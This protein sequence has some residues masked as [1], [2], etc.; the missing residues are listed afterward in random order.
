MTQRGRSKCGGAGIQRTAWEVRESLKRF[1]RLRR[2]SPLRSTRATL[3]P[4]LRFGNRKQNQNSPP[5]TR[6]NQIRA[7][8]ESIRRTF[9]PACPSRCVCVYNWFSAVCQ[10]NP[11]PLAEAK[12]CRGLS[13]RDAALPY[14]GP[15]GN[16]DQERLELGV[17]VIVREVASKL[18]TG[19][20]C[21][22]FVEANGRK[23]ELRLLVIRRREYARNARL[24]HSWGI[25]E[26][27]TWTLP[28]RRLHPPYPVPPR[29]S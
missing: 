5:R 25:S 28:A 10:R 27:P 18:A 11:L 15:A 7:C 29:S 19:M 6:P 17:L 12:A 21:L 23:I 24:R 3:S 4:A 26:S 2:N 9:P 1:F 20:F 16:G 13:L 8:D 22:D 14:G